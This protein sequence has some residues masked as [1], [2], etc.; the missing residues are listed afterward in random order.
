MSGNLREQQQERGPWDPVFIGGTGRSGTSFLF[1]ITRTTDGFYSFGDLESNSDRLVIMDQGRSIASGSV[2]QLVGETVGDH[3]AL[4]LRVRG[5]LPS[6]GLGDDVCCDGS[7]V[8]ATLED[9]VREL[10][11]LL[12][13]IR[14]AGCHVERLDV[15]R[16]G[17]AEVFMQL[18]GRDL[19][20]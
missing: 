4:T 6:E 16:P 1:R 7:T 5:N 20:E 2:E 13:Q 18:T 17:L 10:P 12:D 11:L 19:R 15:R 14:K 8:A 3:A 9:V